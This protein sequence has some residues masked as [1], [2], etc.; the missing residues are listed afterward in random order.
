M[1]LPNLPSLGRP[2]RQS[3]HPTVGA[4]VQGF[5]GANGAKAISKASDLRNEKKLGSQENSSH[6]KHI[7]E[8]E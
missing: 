1:A 7:V 4:G 5:R 8:F 3:L 6:R 2:S